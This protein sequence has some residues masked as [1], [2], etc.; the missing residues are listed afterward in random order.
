MKEKKIYLLERIIIQ[1]IETVNKKHDILL[2]FERMEIKRIANV[3]FEQKILVLCE[4]V[5]YDSYNL[6]H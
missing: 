4:H 1:K 2:L 5:N 6:H 3:C